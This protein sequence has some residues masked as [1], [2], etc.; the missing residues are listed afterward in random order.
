MRTTENC[1]ECVRLTT[2]LMKILNR[3][4]ELATAQITAFRAK[5]Q[6][7]VLLIGKQMEQAVV[8]RNIATCAQQRHMGEHGRVLLHGDIERLKEA[9]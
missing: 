4:A 7:T 3:L 6:D 1:D 5:D 2:D 8:A 9:S